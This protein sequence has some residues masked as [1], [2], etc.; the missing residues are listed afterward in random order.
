M[1]MFDTQMRLA[2]H[3]GDLGDRW[4][5]NEEWMV[6]VVAVAAAVLAEEVVV[7]AAVV[8]QAV[9]PLPLALRCVLASLSRSTGFDGYARHL[10]VAAVVVA[11][12]LW[13]RRAMSSYVVSTTAARSGV[14]SDFLR[15]D[16]ER[17]EFYS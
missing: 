10:V 15:E 7:A 8:A 17:R 1:G 4:A 6:V 12:C 5:A 13:F 11:C 9:A 16:K 2:V 3:G 14:C